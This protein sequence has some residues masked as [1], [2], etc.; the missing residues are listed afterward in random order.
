V[1]TGGIAKS[2]ADSSGATTSKGEAAS[3]DS[4]Y[5]TS[6]VNGNFGFQ[7]GGSGMVNTKDGGA[8]A[9][10][11]S[12]VSGTSAEKIGGATLMGAYNGVFG[13]ASSSGSSTAAGEGA[14]VGGFSPSQ[15][16]GKTGGYGSGTG[17]L[18]AAGSANIKQEMAYYNALISGSGTAK[19]AAGGSATGSNDVASAGGLGS[20]MSTGSAATGIN[21]YSTY[22]GQ[23]D[24]AATGGFT[25]KG[26][27]INGNDQTLPFSGGSVQGEGS[28]TGTADVSGSL[29]D[30]LYLIV[31]T[32]GDAAFKSSGGGSGFVE[33]LTGSAAGSASGGAS[34]TAEG[35]TLDPF[36]Q[37]F[38]DLIFAASSAAKGN[39]AFIGG[40]STPEAPGATGG[41]GSGSGTLSV[42]GSG[43]GDSV[44]TAFAPIVLTNDGTA[45]GAGTAESSGGG[46]ASGSND[47]GEAGGLGSGLS[48]GSA[49][50]SLYT[51]AAESTLG[52]GTATGMFNSAG[53]GIF[54][55]SG[56]SLIMP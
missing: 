46:Q 16:S 10:S 24:S 51:Y 15:S 37:V 13:Y 41:A 14:S 18:S 40:F 17:T 53:S 11:G 8:I 54:G 7:S 5:A 19:T 33:S 36:Y 21:A 30:Q 50:G 56:D 34:G 4:Y 47:Y 52:A 9:S 32:N 2:S 39:G 27:G 22:G 25:G 48:S 44:L 12:D 42:A 45:F 43:S 55:P 26:S 31:N 29:L 38:G 6:L 20:G 3:P 23:T 28:G 1:Y 35:N 49:S